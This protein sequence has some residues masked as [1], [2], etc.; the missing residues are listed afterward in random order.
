MSQQSSLINIRNAVDY[1]ITPVRSPIRDL[2]IYRIDKSVDVSVLEKHVT[3]NGFTVLGLKCVSHEEATYKSFQL[4]VSMSD[5]AGLF[6]DD[7]LCI[8][9]YKRYYQV[10]Y[11]THTT[12]CGCTTKTR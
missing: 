10:I 5:Y 2:F 11:L 4:T 8:S 7:I 3:D 12:N 1:L 6:N 9:V